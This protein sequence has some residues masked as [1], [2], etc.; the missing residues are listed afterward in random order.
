MSVPAD[1]K[2]S[3]AQ[4][5]QV[6]VYDHHSDPMVGEHVAF[7][8]GDDAIAGT[9][10]EG[11]EKADGTASVVVERRDIGDTA[12][13]PWSEVDVVNSADGV[14]CAACGFPS[15]KS[16]RCEACGHDL[17]GQGATVARDS[18]GDA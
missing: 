12:T 1:L 14:E 13:L 10:I 17:V 5:E 18:G 3:D 7:G 2:R 15:R 6:T 8:T 16:Y 11:R 4:P 9:V